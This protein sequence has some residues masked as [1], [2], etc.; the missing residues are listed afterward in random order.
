MRPAAL[1]RTDPSLCVR[2][3][4]FS[5]HQPRGTC[6]LNSFNCISHHLSTFL[7]FAVSRVVVCRSPVGRPE[8]RPAR[9]DGC[10]PSSPADLLRSRPTNWSARGCIRASPPFLSSAPRRPPQR[11]GRHSMSWSP[12]RLQQADRDQSQEDGH[13]N[14]GQHRREDAESQTAST[15]SRD[16]VEPGIAQEKGA[17][18]QASERQLGAAS[19]APMPSYRGIPAGGH[20]SR[21]RPTARRPPDSFEAG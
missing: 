10:Q 19:K 16:D 3:R 18:D 17:G 11:Y 14:L 4:R 21:S 12:A 1:G 15:M 8:H 5:K 13:G 9:G 20:R 7:A 2:A 6:P